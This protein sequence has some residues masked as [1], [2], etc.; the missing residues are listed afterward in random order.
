MTLAS[1]P[2]TSTEFPWKRRL[3]FFGGLLLTIYFLAPPR[4]VYDHTL[5]NS[6]YATYSYFLTH[7]F[8]WGA[9]VIPMPG[10]LGFLIYGNTYSG[11]LYG[12]RILGDFVLKALF[13]ILLLR[14]FHRA[15]PGKM[16]WAW[17]AGVI[18]IVP[19]VDDLLQDFA[20]LVAAMVLLSEMDRKPNRWSFLAAVLLGGICLIKGNHP[21]TTAL[22]FSAVLLL[23]AWERQWRSMLQLTAIYLAAMLGFWVLAGQ[24]PRNLPSFLHASLQLSVGYNAAM[25]LDE[26]PLYTVA[27]LGLA[28]TLALIFSWAAYVGSRQKRAIIA[29]L[30]IAGF[31][32][33]KWKHGYVRADGHVYIFFMS[34]SVFALTICLVSLTQAMGLAPRPLTIGMRRIGLAL[35]TL[36]A[37]F[38]VLVSSE[39]RF[40]TLG[41]FLRAGPSALQRNARYLVR[42]GEFRAPLDR[43]LELNRRAALAPQIQNEVGREPVDFFGNE[44]G[45]ILLN[46]LNYRPRP[47]GGGTFNVFNGWVQDKNEAFVRDPRRAPP[48]QILRLQTIDGR[49]PAADDGPALRA[50]LENYNPVLMQ[51]DYLLFHRRAAPANDGRPNLIATQSAALG[52]EIAVPAVQPDEMVLFTINAPLSIAGQIRAFFYRPPALTAKIRSDYRPAGET[53]VLKPSMLQRPIILSPLLVDNS[54]VLKL[55]SD[56][57]RNVV[58]SLT[59]RAQPGFATDELSVTFYSVPRPAKP[60]SADVAE[61]L[62]YRNFPLYNRIPLNLVTQ[63]TG[64]HEI[65]DEPITIVHAPGSITWDLKPGDQQ[66]IFSYGMM[67]QSYLD[68][69]NTD[70]VGFNVEVIWPPNDGRIVFKRLLLPFTVA[71]DRGMQRARVFLPPFEPGARLRI[72]TD[73][74]PGMNGAYDQSYITRLQIKSGPLVPEQ[75]SGLGTVPADGKLPH[76]SVASVGQDPVFLVHA[77][78]KLVVNIPPASREISGSMGL[79]PSAYLN[80]GQSDGVDFAFDVI[81][82]SGQK[83]ELLKRTLDP[84]H[85][86]ADR[87]VQPFKLALPPL[88]DGSQLMIRTSPGP[89]NNVSWDQSYVSQLKFK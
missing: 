56:R 36:A 52:A 23:G 6:N 54:D 87:G 58:R 18:F 63:E 62:T 84:V 46:D 20:I 13:T 88:P 73:T 24:D 26:D 68:G 30:M 71:A 39:F 12:A 38:G 64:I 41:V 74:G 21:V 69:G 60:D 81:P 78:G 2:R 40:G 3:W 44:E 43:K 45:L 9:D 17:L 4:A 51:R 5:D 31:S 7:H 29:L 86:D 28:A 70:G 80:G 15:G 59:L 19:L 25:G 14:L 11:E 82:P 76:L 47:M 83:I 55:Y 49:F 16:R 48:W 37:G 53:F 57:A 32:F 72:R 10:P 1:T 34:S 79:L 65:N 85:R 27:G 75:F 42:P 22:C 50:L 67:P 35:V 77:P 33:I 66:V 61:I 89:A 8:Q